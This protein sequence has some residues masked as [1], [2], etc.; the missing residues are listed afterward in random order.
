MALMTWARSTCRPMSQPRA[1]RRT[2]SVYTH[3]RR[4]PRREPD[5]FPFSCMPV[6]EPSQP[7]RATSHLRFTSV[8]GRHSPAADA[9]EGTELLSESNEGKG[10]GG[11]RLT[12]LHKRYVGF[13]D[14]SL[15][16]REGPR[17]ASFLTFRFPRRPQGRPRTPAS[18]EGLG[19]SCADGQPSTLGPLLMS[20]CQE[21]PQRGAGGHPHTTAATARRLSRSCAT[22]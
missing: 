2:R 1:A 14:A 19:L 22:F 20:P 6:L 4:H 11:P 21:P 7:R 9:H 17:P 10:E 18:E 16:R 13:C 8:R 15:Q 5:T 3:S 12:T